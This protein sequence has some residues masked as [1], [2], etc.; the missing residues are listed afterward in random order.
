MILP[1][2]GMRL[3]MELTVWQP[4]SANCATWM[5]FSAGAAVLILKK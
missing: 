3:R 2:T 5:T 4:L 1:E